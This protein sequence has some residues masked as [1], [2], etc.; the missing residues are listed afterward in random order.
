MDMVPI[1][2]SAIDY[3]GYDEAAA[4]LHIIFVNNPKTYVY[5]GVPPHIFDGFIN[6]PSKGSYFN[7]YIKDVYSYL[8]Q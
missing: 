1:V 4:E 3:A 8:V 2:S 6:A 5:Q 7:Q